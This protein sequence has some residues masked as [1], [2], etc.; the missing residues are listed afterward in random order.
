[1]TTG[2]SLVSIWRDNITL[3]QEKAAAI[4]AAI[5]E[6]KREARVECADVL[7]RAGYEGSMIHRAILDLNAPPAPAYPF[8]KP[9]QCWVYSVPDAKA[10]SQSNWRR[11][12][13]THS[14][15]VYACPDA[16]YC[17]VCGAPRTKGN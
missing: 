2:E 7:V 5:A 12:L 10:E 1:M 13:S 17:E 4:N 9:C 15:Y 14:T 16:A 8:E 3:E 11:L 6:A